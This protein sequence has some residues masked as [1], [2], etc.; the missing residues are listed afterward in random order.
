M[1]KIA[2]K[3]TAVT[4]ALA[5]VFSAATMVGNTA[6]AAEETTLTSSAQVADLVW[7]GY[8]EGELGPISITEGEL[9]GTDVYLV[10]LSGTE[11][12]SGQSTGYLTDLLSGFNLNNAYYE[13]VV[14]VISDTVPAGSNLVLA[15]HSLGGMIAQQVAANDTIKAN[16]NILNTVCFGS[17][18]L[19]A[20][21]REGTVKR[22]GDTSDVVP[23]L[24]GSMFNNTIW[25][26]AGLNRENGGYGWSVV[27]AHTQSYLRDDVWGAYDVVGA[28]N[29]GSTLTLDL[30]TRTFYQSDAWV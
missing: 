2:K 14:A 6:L 29:G 26:I 15:G 11:D 8:N 19:S 20:G 25:A 24:S 12:V 18:L 22:L 1:R 17:P 5:T 28:K 13:N 16:Y 3:F 23:Y 4:L 21:S 9:N 27:D 7:D 10:T 30:D